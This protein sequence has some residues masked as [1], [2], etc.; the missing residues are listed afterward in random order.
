MSPRNSAPAIVKMLKE[1]SCHKLLTTQET[2]KSIVTEVVDLLEKDN[3]ALEIVEMPPL[4][5]I[6]PRLGVET[7]ADPF[8]EYPKAA[9]R[10]GLDDAML[11][12]HSSGSTGFPKSIKE[13]YRI[14]CHWAA[15]GKAAPPDFLGKPN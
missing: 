7:A 14:F 15:F 2:L 8:E 13:T 6:F 1:V 5:E 3:Y 4:Y 11:Y 10:P 9:V 12:L